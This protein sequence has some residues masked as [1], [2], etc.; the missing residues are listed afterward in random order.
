MPDPNDPKFV[1][2]VC[3]NIKAANMTVQQPPCIR[4]R[5]TDMKL[6]KL[7]QVPGLEWSRRWSNRTLKDI[8]TW[9]SE[10]TITIQV[11]EGYTSTPLKL[12]VRK[13][14]PAKGDVLQRSWVG[15]GGEKKSVTIPPY[16]I[17]D[18]TAAKDAYK[19]Y[20]NEGGAEFFLGALDP[21]DE[22]VKFL[23]RTYCMAII[24]SNDNDVVGFLP[25]SSCS[26]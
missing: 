22:L 15:K 19:R 11:S 10:D 3:K 26:Y 14:N 1:C 12:I 23:W 8:D 9:A 5:V 25:L 6:Y 13:F 4:H 21:K 17:Q 20:I 18:L 7:G 24:T 2:L 16:A